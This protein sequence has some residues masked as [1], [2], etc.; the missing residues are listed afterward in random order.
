MRADPPGGSAARLESL[1]RTGLDAAADPTFDRFA[2]MVRT[3]LNVPVALVSL[4]SDDR[5][6]FP[7]ACGLGDPWAQARQTPLSHSFCRHVVETAEPLVVIDARNDPRVQGNLAITELGVVGYAGMPLTDAD[8][9]VLGSL[10]AIDTEPRRWTDGEL[11]LLADLAAACS[12]SLRLRIAAFQAGAGFRRTQLLLRASTTLGDADTVDKV[13]DAVRDLVTGTLDPA[14]VG[15]SL[16]DDHHRVGLTSKRLLPPAVATRWALYPASTTTPSAMAARTGKPV[17]VPDLDAVA[18]TTPDALATFTEMGWQ[19]AASVPLPGPAGPAG[20]LTFVWKEPYAVDDEEQVVLAALAGFVVQALTRARVLDD[21]RTAAAVM[22]KALLTPLPSHN[23]V[24]MAARYAPAHH[25]DHVGGDWYDA[26]SLDESRLALIIGDTTGHS[27]E[28]AA[29]M[30]QYR[31]MLRTLVIDRHEP[32]SAV[33]RRLETTRRTIGS[34][35]LATVVLAYL[36]TDPAG[37]HRLTWTNAGHPAPVLR[38]PDGQVVAL[39]SHDTL[40]GVNRRGSRLNQTRLVPPGSLLLLHT[41]GLV[42]SRTA[43]IDEGLA[44]LHRLLAEHRTDDPEELADL[45]IGQGGA[46]GEDDI[47]LLVIATPS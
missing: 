45:L 24:R 34:D 14:Y 30:S 10:C 23:D 22:Q 17:L 40:I 27:I 43:T 41:D 36:D 42:E 16:L 1:R 6:V 3:V 35:S 28:A 21:R 46:A 11:T 15:I 13:I 4:V 25:E 12:D 33:L 29:A 9:L 32:P 7:G 31:S 44:G 47:A 8:G 26:I 20:A 19:S 39:G 38:L 5:Q 37:G 18:A 2:S